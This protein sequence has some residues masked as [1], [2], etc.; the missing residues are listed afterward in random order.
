MSET[1]THKIFPYEK[2]STQ[3]KKSC[4]VNM[5]EKVTVTKEIFTSIKTKKMS[6]HLTHKH[7]P[8]K[9]T[10]STPLLTL[11]RVFPNQP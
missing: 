7:G 10:L 5:S 6:P 1:R 8:N 9:K 3:P 11:D 2:R 4:D